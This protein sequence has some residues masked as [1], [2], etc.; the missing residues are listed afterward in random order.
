WNLDKSPAGSSAGSGAAV[1]AKM[2]AIAIGSQT[3]GSMLRPAAFNGS[4]GLK[5]TYGWISVEGVIPL[6][7]SLDHLGLYG[8]TVD[9]VSQVFNTLVG[10]SQEA[11]EVPAPPRIALLT[12]FLDMSEPDVA[13]H[14]QEI[15]GKLENAGATVVR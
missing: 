12:E 3:G 1:P 11:V 5:P 10:A 4:V 13:A 7:W 9:D 6:C 2:A 14:I 8:T 15:A